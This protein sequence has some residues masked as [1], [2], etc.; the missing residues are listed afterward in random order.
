ML[1]AKAR[2]DDPKRNFLKYEAAISNTSIS[3][4]FSGHI[5]ELGMEQNGP[6]DMHV[7][8]RTEAE[9][10]LLESEQGTTHLEQRHGFP[11]QFPERY[12]GEVSGMCSSLFIDI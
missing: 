10:E 6:I 12:V 8:C 3:F 5:G 9:R 2:R 11:E 1:K 7:S 4:W